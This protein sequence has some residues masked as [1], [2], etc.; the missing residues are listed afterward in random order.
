MIEAIV[1]DI[2]GTTSSIAFVKEL[3]FPYSRQRMDAFLREAADRPEVREALEMTR[4]TLHEETGT[5]PTPADLLAALLHWI[6]TDRKH[7]GL[8]TLQGLIWKDGYERGELKSH[9]YPDV[10]PKLRAWRDAGLT[11][12]VYSSG[13][14]EA[15]RQF[16]GHSEAGDLRPL[17]SH[18]FDTKIGQK[19]TIE[20]YR[21]IAE[22]LALPP[23]RIL[24]LSDIAEELDAAA[25][26]GL[27]T[28]QLVRPGTT[29]T[30]RHPTARDF[31]EVEIGAVKNGLGGHLAR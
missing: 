4:Q 19:K 9:L 21:T 15:Q 26:T 23:E 13:S 14:E 17:F 7:T 30:D 25:Q 27:R 1:T 29:A 28:V 16:F 5:E 20:P 2:E 18:Y 3:L 11:L 6:D 8:K 22:T 31:D 10:A 12:A 24:F